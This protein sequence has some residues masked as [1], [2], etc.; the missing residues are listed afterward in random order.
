MIF[1][2]QSNSLTPFDLNSLTLGAQVFGLLF[3]LFFFYYL[4]ISIVIPNI[5]GGF[6]LNS[7]RGKKWN[8][9]KKKGKLKGEAT[10]NNSKIS[11]RNSSPRVDFYIDF[12]RYGFYQVFLDASVVRAKF[13]R[14][15]SPDDKDIQSVWVPLALQ[16]MNH[17]HIAPWIVAGTRVIFSRQ[18]QVVGNN[19]LHASGIDIRI[20]D[21]PNVQQ[22][23]IPW[24]Q[25]IE[26]RS[27][28]EDPINGQVI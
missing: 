26:V 9:K 5:L 16:Q 19:F 14:G 12:S 15:T 11:K 21:V 2:T 7:N 27:L 13:T 25:E 1:I 23:P 17:A 8:N 24:Y 18:G 3:T 4:N 22:I 28:G 10:H 6:I 20:H